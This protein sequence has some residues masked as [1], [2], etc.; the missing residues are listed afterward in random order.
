M[1]KRSANS[2]LAL[3]V[4]IVLIVIVAGGWFATE[5][6]GAHLGFQPRLG[7]RGRTGLGL[8][9]YPRGG[10]FQ[11]GYAY[12]AYAPKVFNPGGMIAG[13]AG[14]AGAVGAILGSIWRSRQ[15]RDVTTFGPARR[16][17]TH[18]TTGIAAT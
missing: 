1:N 10:L 6:T 8:P 4:I 2:V 9:L 11:W 5:W 12:G 3:Q 13:G 16:P 14:I 18:T 7:R 17:H 15:A